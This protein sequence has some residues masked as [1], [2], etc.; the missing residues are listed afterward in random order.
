MSE[1]FLVSIARDKLRNLFR[2]PDDNLE[3]GYP[4]SRKRGISPSILGSFGNDKI[5]FTL[6]NTYKMSQEVRVKELLQG[7]MAKEVQVVYRRK[8]DAKEEKL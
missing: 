1:K 8:Y 6:R 5:E 7:V 2:N 3:M 4:A